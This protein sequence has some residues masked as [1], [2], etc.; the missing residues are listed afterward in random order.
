MF[1]TEAD[2]LLSELGGDEAT[3]LKPLIPKFMLTKMSLARAN[4]AQCVSAVELALEAKKGDGQKLV[5]EI[6]AAITD[7]QAAF[8]SLSNLVSE[9]K[10]HLE[11]LVKATAGA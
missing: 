7:A 9:A 11:S 2:E 5:K 10:E 1:L 8:D 3:Q 6:V 4:V